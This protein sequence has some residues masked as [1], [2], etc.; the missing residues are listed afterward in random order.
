MGAT[1][2]V[3]SWADPD[4]QTQTGTVYKT[5]LDNDLIVGKR[6]TDNF[7]PH[8]KA[9]PDMNVLIDAGNIFIDQVLTE[10][11]Q[12]TVGPFTAPT[13]NPRI[14][15]IVK[16][17]T[18]GNAEIVAGTE[19]PSPSPPAIPGEKDPN[20][21]VKLI[22][23][24]T[25]ITNQ[26]ITDE[27]LSGAGGALIRVLNKTTADTTVTGGTEATFY[28]FSIAG[29]ILGTD[30]TLILRIHVTDA[31][32]LG[33]PHTT[34]IRC[35]YGGT[36]FAALTK[37]IN[38]S[39]N[40]RYILIV[41]LSAEGATNSQ[42]GS[43]HFTADDSATKTDM[44]GGTAAIDSTTAQTLLITVQHDDANPSTTNNYAILEQHK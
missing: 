4:F 14:D 16:D 18:T 32:G 39:T 5:N 33:G 19:A 30:N 17:Q 15:R 35:K 34:T 12:Q 26:D 11:A 9:T 6:I 2:P 21:Q 24:Q 38:A 40:D 42:I 23:G 22:V 3:G 31:F 25:S 37:T 13:T 1:N 27:R 28:T 41:I 36:V 10:K 44:G 7:A 8:E 43:A 20:C 29:G